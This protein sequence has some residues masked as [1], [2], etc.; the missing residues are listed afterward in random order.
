MIAA[1]SSVSVRDLSADVINSLGQPGILV[2][3]VSMR[4]GKPTILAVCDGV[5][6]FGLP[7]NPVSAM[8]VCE[9]FVVPT[10]R[11]LLGESA[12]RPVQVMARLARNL[13]STAG[14]EDYVPVRLEERAGEL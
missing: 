10:V 5:P 3:G 9:L 14:R 12:R 8:V 4:P 11:T 13:A 1:G 2:H 6:V 7:G